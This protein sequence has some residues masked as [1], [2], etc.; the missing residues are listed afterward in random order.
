MNAPAEFTASK[1]APQAIVEELSI[2][3]VNE[4]SCVECSR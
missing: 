2:V 1:I 3:M 4:C